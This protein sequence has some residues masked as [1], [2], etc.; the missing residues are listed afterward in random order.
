MVVWD[1]T[2]P[3]LAL[4][5]RFILKFSH[6]RERKLLVDITGKFERSSPYAVDREVEKSKVWMSAV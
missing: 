4:Q 5:P 6:H 3:A 2:L 1:E